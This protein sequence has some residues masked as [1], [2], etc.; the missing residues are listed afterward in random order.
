[1]RISIFRLF[2]APSAEVGGGILIAFYIV[3][4]LKRKEAFIM[5]A[6]SPN[7]RGKLNFKII[8]HTLPVFSKIIWKFRIARSGKND[9]ANNQNVF[10]Y[11]VFS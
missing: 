9:V 10:L 11:I 1:M 3:G 7:M 6:A 5:I 8:F 4:C 2:V